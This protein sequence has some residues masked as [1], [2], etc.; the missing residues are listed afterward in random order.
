[1][2]KNQ[3][4][5]TY[6]LGKN[7]S[8]ECAP[9][10]QLDDGEHAPISQLTFPELASFASHRLRS[11]RYSRYAAHDIARRTS[12]QAGTDHL[13]SRAPGDQTDTAAESGAGEGSL[14]RSAHAIAAH[15]GE[16]D[17]QQDQSRFHFVF[18]GQCR[19]GK[20]VLP[21]Q[22]ATFGNNQYGCDFLK[23]LFQKCYSESSRGPTKANPAS[24]DA[25]RA[26]PT[27]S[28]SRIAMAD[29]PQGVSHRA[30][31]AVSQRH[32]LLVL[33]CA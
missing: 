1:M 20:Y 4:G 23:S 21:N 28:G 13:A 33:A 18:S 10:S 7:A 6:C 29:S 11:P 26:S 8:S 30:L 17:G 22:A 16:R 19:R 9:C 25:R 12:D 24:L 2:D 3:L 31:L 15:Q 14:L 5:C 27:P 32:A